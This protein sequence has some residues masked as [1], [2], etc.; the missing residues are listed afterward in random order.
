M[1]KHKNVLRFKMVY[2]LLKTLT[3]IVAFDGAEHAE[4][5]N[6][7]AAVLHQAV[8]VGTGTELITKDSGIAER[9]CDRVQRLLQMMKHYLILTSL[10]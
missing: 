10:K 8:Q 5:L 2:H 1:Y 7:P 9:S 6:K 3:D 4:S